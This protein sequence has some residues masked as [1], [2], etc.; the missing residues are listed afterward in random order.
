[1]R[2][3]RALIGISQ[4]ELAHRAGVSVPTIKRCESEGKNIPI[5][6]PETQQKIRAVL[7]GEGIEF[8]PENG[9]GVGVR[10]R[11]ISSVE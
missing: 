6:S 10:L 8:I 11:K 3:A 9:G 5:V 2:A 1:M 4:A 7:E